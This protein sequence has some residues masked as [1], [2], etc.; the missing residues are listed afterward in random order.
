MDKR[1]LIDGFTS[2]HSTLIANLT[3]ID[4]K[5]SVAQ[6]AAGGNCINWIAGHLLDARGGMLAMLGG[7]P[8]LNE[9]EKERYKR[10][11]EPIRNGDAHTDVSRI[12]EGLN[13][14]HGQVITA[15]EAM[16]DENLDQKL[17]ESIFPTPVKHP[18]L[19]TMLALFLF[20]EG[21]HTGQ[22]GLARYAAGKAAVIK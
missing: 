17:D 14:T 4:D 22:L 13:K 5:A 7:E 11:S 19:G 1:T 12:T 2:S 20:H 8:F 15:L 18:T 21:Y 16:P 10:G 3:D 6:P 9:E